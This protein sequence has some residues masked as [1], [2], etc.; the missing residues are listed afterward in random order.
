MH[1]NLGDIEKEQ[2]K[3]DYKNRRKEMYD[4]LDYVKKRTSKKRGQQKKTKCD[5]LDDNGEKQFRKYM[6][7]LKKFMR[8]NLSDKKK[9]KIFKKRD[10]KRKKH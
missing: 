7:E 8:D 3:K 5:N 2:F 6:K 9:K 4:N 10:N 1:G